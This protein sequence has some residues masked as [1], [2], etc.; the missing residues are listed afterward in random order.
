MRA[1]KVKTQVNLEQINK[2]VQELMS[3]IS[4]DMDKMNNIIS[5]VI[6]VNKKD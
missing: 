2:E 1:K 3:L 4:N 6:E 5:Q